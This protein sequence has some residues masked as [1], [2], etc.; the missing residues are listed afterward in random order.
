MRSLCEGQ[1]LSTDINVIISAN[2]NIC[3]CD[4]VSLHEQVFM[5][6]YVYLPSPLQELDSLMVS[7]APQV[8]PVNLQQS[9]TCHT[10]KHK[11]HHH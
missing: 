5:P 10:H 4:C 1:S 11:P 9:V 2:E 6:V 7:H 3:V 8:G